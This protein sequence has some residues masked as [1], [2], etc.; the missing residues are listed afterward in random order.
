MARNDP[1]AVLRKRRKQKHRL[2]NR[3]IQRE[4]QQAEQDAKDAKAS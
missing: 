2:A 3:Q 4:A 1:R